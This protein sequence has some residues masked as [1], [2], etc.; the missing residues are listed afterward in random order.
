MEIMIQCPPLNRAPDN[1]ASRLLE[2][3]RLERIIEEALIRRQFC[4]RIIEQPL[5]RAGLPGPEGALLSSGHCI[6]KN[7]NTANFYDSMCIFF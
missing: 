1:R 4:L 5:I 3:F 2:Q 6:L 7:R